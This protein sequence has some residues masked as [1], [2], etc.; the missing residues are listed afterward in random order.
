MFG[1]ART[2]RRRWPCTVAAIVGLPIFLLVAPFASNAFG[3][4]AAAASPAQTSISLQLGRVGSAANSMNVEATG[5][6]PGDVAERTLDVLLGAKTKARVSLSLRIAKSS[7]LDRR[8]QDGLQV[9]ILGCSVPWTE[10]PALRYSCRRGS[11]RTLLASRPLSRAKLGS[12]LVLAQASSSTTFHLRVMLTLPAS[13]GNALQ[14][15]VSVLR[16][17][18]SALPA[19][20]R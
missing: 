13:A 5:M 19:H 9:T 2:T 8:P 1:A 4:G 15:Q 10:G 20:V 14:G 16:F 3:T 12:P 7:L 11:P 18:V 6:R 17:D